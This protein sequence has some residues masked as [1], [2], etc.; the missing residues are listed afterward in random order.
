MKNH[1]VN[2]GDID[3]FGKWILFMI[4]IIL[5]LVLI[6]HCSCNTDMNERQNHFQKKMDNYDTI[7]K[8]SNCFI[9]AKS[10]YK[11][12]VDSGIVYPKVVCQQAILETGCFKSNYFLNKNNLFG[13]SDDNGYRHYNNIYDCISYYKKFQKTRF[14][15]WQNSDN[16]DLNDNEVYYRFLNDYGYAKDSNYVSVL[17]KIKI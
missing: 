2:S 10:L 17:R 14:L 4:G 12:L 9:C 7:V 13:F 5:A 1:V 6:G 8:D 11:L 15:M 16:L 3:P